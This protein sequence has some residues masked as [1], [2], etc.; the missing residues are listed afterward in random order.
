RGA[1]DGD[2]TP[3][4][5]GGDDTSRP[6]G[7]GV[8]R[9]RYRRGVSITNQILVRG[10][11]RPIRATPGHPGWRWN[12]VCWHRAGVTDQLLVDYL[13]PSRCPPPGTGTARTGARVPSAPAAPRR[14]GRGAGRTAPGSAA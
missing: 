10:P 4:W 12:G 1:G 11:G 13:R 6:A 14:T 3:R 7:R 2:D 5:S 8:S 9:G